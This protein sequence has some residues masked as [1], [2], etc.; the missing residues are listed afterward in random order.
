MAV[1]LKAPEEGDTENAKAYED[2][3]NAA[4]SEPRKP[5]RHSEHSA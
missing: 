3:V 4:P 2:A 1:H 5:K